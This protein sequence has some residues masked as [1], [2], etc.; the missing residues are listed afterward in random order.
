MIVK[1]EFPGIGEAFAAGSKKKKVP[2]K[3][4]IEAQK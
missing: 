2:T 1:D 3:E 4:E